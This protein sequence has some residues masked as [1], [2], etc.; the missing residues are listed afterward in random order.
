LVRKPLAPARSASTMY[1]SRP[2]VVRIEHAVARQPARRLDAVRA[3]HAD[4]HQDDVG[5]VRSAARIASSP[6]SASATTS[7]ARSPRA[8]S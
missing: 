4:V 1:S 7:I 2:N 6:S 3:R 8:R 5:R